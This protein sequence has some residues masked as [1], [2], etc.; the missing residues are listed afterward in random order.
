MKILSHRGFWLSDVEK[1]TPDAFTRSFTAGFGTETDFRD[2]NGQLVVAHDPPLTGVMTAEAFLELHAQYDISLPLALNIKADG[3]QKMFVDLLE[4]F[5]PIDAFVFDMSIPDTLHW[6]NEGVPVF[7][8][9]SDIEPDPVLLARAAGIWLDSFESDWWN[10]GTIR[11]HLDAGL[12]VCIVSPELHKRPYLPVWDRLAAAGDLLASP[13]LMIC[14]DHPEIAKGYF[15][16]G[17]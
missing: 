2:F 4:R 15:S 1:N 9:H 14:T 6:L 17:D 5:A 7:I 12:R 3:L 11:R 10:V 16:H 13:E 8:R